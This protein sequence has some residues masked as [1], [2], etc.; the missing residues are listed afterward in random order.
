MGDIQLFDDDLFPQ[1]ADVGNVGFVIDTTDKAEWALSKIGAAETRIAD[2]TERVAFVIARL[3]ERLEHITAT[4]RASVERLTD[5]LRPWANVEIAKRAGPRSVKTLAGVVGFRQ[6]PARVEVT[7]LEGLPESCIRIKKEADKAAIKALIE[8]TGEIPDGVEL[9]PGD[10]KFYV[11]ATSL[12]VE[13][14]EAQ[15]G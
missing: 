7:S 8:S 1:P 6:S 4:D 3:K 11:E 9:V 12:M 13:K 2:A 10:V 14:K 5:M 15:I